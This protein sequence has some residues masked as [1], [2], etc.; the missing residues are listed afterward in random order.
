MTTVEEIIAESVKEYK[1]GKA[2]YRRQEIYKLI[3]YYSG[4]ETQKYI[5]GFFDADAFREIPVYSANFTKRFINKMSRI[6]NV[7][8]NR[9]VGESYDKLTIKKDARMKHIEKMTR[10]VG[11]VATQV[12]YRDDLE[13][14]CFD[15]RP[16]Y[17]F[18]VH[19]E[20]NPFVP[21]A[22]TYPIL[23]SVD[24]IGDTSNLH[25]AYWDNSIYALY[26]ESGNI[27]EEYEHGYGVIPFVF[28]HR[29][30][31]IDSFFVEGACDI[32]E[33][34]EQ[35]NI[36]MTELQL[37]LRFQMFGQPFVTGVYSDKGMKRAGSDSI[38][39]LPEGSTFGIAAPQG[40]IQSVIESV[41]FQVDLVAQ[42]NH[43]YVQF[44]QDGGEVPSGIALKIKD[45]ER[46]EDY[47]DDIELWRMYEHEL[48]AV[49]RQIAAYNGVPLPKELKLDFIEPEYPKT[50]QD[51]ILIENHALQNNLVTQPQLLQKYNKDLTIEEARE[52]VRANKQEN[53][54]QSIFERIRQQNQRT[55]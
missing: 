48:Y 8:A 5:E 1:L 37:G 15:Y 54:Q 9:N 33:C 30:N 42:N 41:K 49:E 27:L 4:S 21:T 38:L 40:D 52:I 44:A 16:I 13:Y 32:V 53:E 36:T 25:Y 10:L 31:Q 50:V 29:E 20:D 55:Q 11:T 7:G 35:V 3:D 47:Q 23:N 12:I 39:D 43:L 6:Y 46:F 28:T 45:L 26:D 14:P 22:I 17:Y 51:Q 19:M 34:N 2:K 18:D 24:D